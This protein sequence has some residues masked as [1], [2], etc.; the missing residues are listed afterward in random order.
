[1][2]S[3]VYAIF[4]DDTQAF[5]AAVSNAIMLWDDILISETGQTSET[6]RDIVHAQF[7]LAGLTGI[8]EVL[9]HQGIDVYSLKSNRLMK[10]Y[11]Y[12]AS[13]LLGEVPEDVKG[14][15][16]NWVG[17]NPANWEMVYAHYVNRKGLEMPKSKVVVESHRPEAFK[18]NWGLGT[19]THYTPPSSKT[20]NFAFLW[21]YFLGK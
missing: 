4:K 1:M 3:L 18:F 19:L 2:A 8:A 12:H 15:K 5:T 13:I 7:G 14:V 6:L 10:A 21:D 16:L 20:S 9:W 17:Y 11:E